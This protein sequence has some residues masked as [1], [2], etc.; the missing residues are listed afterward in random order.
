M[1]PPERQ[2][3]HRHDGVFGIDCQVE[4]P[5]L[6]VRRKGL[7]AEFD[8]FRDRRVGVPHVELLACELQLRR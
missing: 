5:L 3:L 8:D 7:E 4:Q 2:R 6:R 1:A